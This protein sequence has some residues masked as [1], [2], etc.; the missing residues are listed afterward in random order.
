MVPTELKYTHNSEALSQFMYKMK[1][2][3]PN[4]Y[5]NRVCKNYV[6]SAGYL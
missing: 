6:H 5:T 1:R 4:N 2:R 3:N